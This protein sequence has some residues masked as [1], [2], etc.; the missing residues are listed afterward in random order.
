MPDTVIFDRFGLPLVFEGADFSYLK[1]N[2]E[3]LAPESPYEK[4]PF[5]FVKPFSNTKNRDFLYR[6][7][8]EYAD[9]KHPELFKY[10]QSQLPKSVE[11]DKLEGMSNNIFQHLFALDFDIDVEKDRA[12]QRFQPKRRYWTLHGNNS[13]KLSQNYLTKNWYKG[14]AGNLNL[15]NNHNFTFNYSKNKVEFNNFAE[16]KLS[17]FNSPNDTLRNLRI[18]EDLVRTY[19]TLGLKAAKNWSYSVNMELKTQLFRNYKENNTD[20]IT[21]FMSPFMANIGLLGMKYQLKKTYPKVKGKNLDLSLDIAPLSIQYTWVASS[22]VNPA[23]YGIAEGK[24]H[25]AD[26]GSTLNAKL[27]MYFNKNVNLTSRVKYFTNYESA[28]QAEWENTL[29]MPINR[30]FSTMIYVYVRYDDSNGIKK[31]P[32]L[33]YFQLS[34]MLSFGFNYTW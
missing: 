25:K 19:S 10:T 26:F 14:G 17:L 20:V 2:V 3:P 4:L 18:G 23:L 33:G 7:F 31:D 6:S 28:Q 15:Q 30:Y 32:K 27:V 16:W 22:N 34:E 9:K 24:R 5:P 13:V 29:N 1:L 8:L 21:S 12:P 11:I